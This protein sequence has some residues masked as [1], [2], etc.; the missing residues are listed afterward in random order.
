MIHHR[1]AEAG[2]IETR[3]LRDGLVPLDP[4][5]FDAEVATFFPEA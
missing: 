3:V 5:A 1:R 2:V 4:P